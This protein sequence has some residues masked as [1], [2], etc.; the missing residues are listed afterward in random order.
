MLCAII[1]GVEDHIH[2]MA[3]LHPTVCVADL[4][5][6]IK[7]SSNRFIKENKLCEN[8]SC[9]QI[10]YGVFSY[11]MRQKEVLYNYIKN[12]EAHHAKKSYEEE[13]IGFL[14]VFNI[15]YDEKYVFD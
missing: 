11:S 9:W 2:I 6:A 10:S 3:E 4:V 5:K 12:Q 15:P 7:I 1:N 14:K 13:Y 8:F